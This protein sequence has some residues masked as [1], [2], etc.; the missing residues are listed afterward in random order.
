MGICHLPAALCP[1]LSACSRHGP[2]RSFSTP[3]VAEPLRPS[4]IACSSVVFS[5]RSSAR[6]CLPRPG[7]RTAH[8]A[9]LPRIARFGGG[10][11]GR[12]FALDYA[13][14]SFDAL[15]LTTHRFGLRW[16]R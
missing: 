14:Q 9:P 2:C 13:Y 15:A 3:R 11:R 4:R 1:L 5:Q 12:Q 16:W 6:R 7:L 8:T 10:V